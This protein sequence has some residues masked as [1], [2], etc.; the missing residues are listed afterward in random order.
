MTERDAVIGRINWGK[1][2]NYLNILVFS[3]DVLWV[4]SLRCNHD[5]KLMNFFF[6]VKWV[7]VR[8]IWKTL[9]FK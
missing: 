5:I 6:T 7:E 9:F 1:H 8:E 3:A 2:F 4:P